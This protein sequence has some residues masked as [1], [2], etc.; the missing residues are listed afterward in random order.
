MLTFQNVLMWQTLPSSV[1]TCLPCVMI[2]GSPNYRTAAYEKAF[3]VVYG[4][5]CSALLSCK[6]IFLESCS[7][8]QLP[9]CK[10]CWSNGWWKQLLGRTFQAWNDEHHK[11]WGRR[12]SDTCS[13]PWAGVCCL[14]IE[15]V[16]PL[17][18]GSFSFYVR[19]C[20]IVV[21]PCN[22]AWKRKQLGYLKTNRTPTIA[23]KIM[24]ILS[25]TNYKDCQCYCIF[26]H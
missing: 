23:R 2:S 11:W 24:Q 14:V 9:G 6:Q 17:V 18:Q 22:C 8:Y 19:T 15:I 21:E 3:P 25:L 12:F 20:F 1:P 5:Y 26:L 10:A 13:G 7:W 4:A 16:I